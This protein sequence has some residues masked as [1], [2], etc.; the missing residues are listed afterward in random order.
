[1]SS[2]EGIAE[3]GVGLEFGGPPRTL[4]LLATALQILG[5]WHQAS[6]SLISLVLGDRAAW[7]ELCLCISLRKKVMT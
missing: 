5:H 7:R 3:A 2:L 6:R 4:P 1:M